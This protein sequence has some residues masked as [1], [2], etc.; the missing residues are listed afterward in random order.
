MNLSAAGN[1]VVPAYLSLL[2]K[3]FAVSCVRALDGT[4]TWTA[5]GA[6]G[7]FM[8]DDVITLLGVVGVAE[9]RGANWAASDSE[10]DAF[11][12]KFGYESGT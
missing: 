6:L 5:E 7:R 3:G 8:A 11:L 12:K 10:I 2:A 9:V 4:E 1:V